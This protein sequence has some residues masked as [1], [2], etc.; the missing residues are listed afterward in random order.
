MI[1]V[2]VASTR[3]FFPSPRTHACARKISCV[4]KRLCFLFYT[5]DPQVGICTV[6]LAVTVYTQIQ[7]ASP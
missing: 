3:G 4:T 7:Q 2:E 5:G 6:R 1:P